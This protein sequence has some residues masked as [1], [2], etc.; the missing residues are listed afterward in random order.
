MVKNWI[1]FFYGILLILLGFVGYAQ[2]SKV[3]LYSGGSFGVLL[4]VSAILLFRGIQWSSYLALALTSA[5]TLIFS[6]RYS[7][8]G[9]NLPGIL[10]ALSGAMLIYL[11]AQTV[12]WRRGGTKG[13]HKNV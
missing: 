13:F 8:T 11:L 5:L 12:K 6:V 7:V 4:V 1:I 10:A 2:G 3:S 9:K